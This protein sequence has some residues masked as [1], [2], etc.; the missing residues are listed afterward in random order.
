MTHRTSRALHWPCLEQNQWN[1]LY[2]GKD[3]SSLFLLPVGMRAEAVSSTVKE[4]AT[5]GLLCSQVPREQEA[6]AAT[7]YF[8]GSPGSFTFHSVQ[9]CSL[10]LS[11]QS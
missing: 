2:T 9:Q 7:L 3:I 1:R 8:S 4:R 5:E 11:V 10:P 6:R